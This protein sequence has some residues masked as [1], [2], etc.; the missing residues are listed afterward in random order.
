MRNGCQ[1]MKI[2][3]KRIKKTARLCSAVF[4]NQRLEI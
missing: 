4:E 3:L 2:G 1:M